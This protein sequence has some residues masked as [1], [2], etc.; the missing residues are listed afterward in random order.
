MRTIKQIALRTIII[1][2][3]PWLTLSSGTAEAAGWLQ[4]HK[5]CYAKI[6]DRMLLGKRSYTADGLRSFQDV[7]AYQDHLLNIYAECGISQSVTFTLS[8]APIGYATAETDSFYVGPLILG[9]RI[10]LKQKG[11]WKLAL[12]MGFG[13]APGVGDTVLSRSRYVDDDGIERE[14]IYQPTIDNV[15]AQLV[16]EAG[17]GFKLGS[18]SSYFSS[19]LGVRIN[20]ASQVDHALLVSAQWGF[21]LFSQRLII[22]MH[23]NLYEPFFQPVTI[24]N[25]AGAGQTR[26]LGAG[27]TLSYWFVKKLALFLTFDGVFYAESNAATPSLGFGIETRFSL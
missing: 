14:A 11:R 17:T 13:V 18:L 25:T 26:Y 6:Y 9:A 23:F 19:T 27:L 8:M 3:L 5:A 21:L 22:D 24:T 20:G 16:I 2:A 12:A 1:I 10:G 15:L 4:A 7:P